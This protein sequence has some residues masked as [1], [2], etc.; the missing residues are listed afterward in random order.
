M[1]RFARTLGFDSYPAMREVL[2]AKF[3]SLV[4]HSAR[5]RSRLDD[6]HAPGIFS[7]SLS[8]QKLHS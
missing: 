1:V 3:R 5:I 6:Y 7:N 4:I 8:L 2:Q